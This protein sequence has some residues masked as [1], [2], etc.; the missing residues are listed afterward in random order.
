MKK[1][2]ICIYISFLFLSSRGGTWRL[3]LKMV[4]VTMGYIMM[5][6]KRNEE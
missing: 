1:K 2:K 4:V 3:D 5:C 6:M